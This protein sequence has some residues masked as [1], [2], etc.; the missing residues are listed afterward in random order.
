VH[1]AGQLANLNTDGPVGTRS[2]SGL[3]VDA[4]CPPFPATAKCAGVART[5]TM[6]SI[7][8]VSVVFEGNP[9]MRWRS[10]RSWM[11]QLGIRLLERTLVIFDC[12]ES[13]VIL[14]PRQVPQVGG[15]GR[16]GRPIRRQHTASRRHGNRIPLGWMT[17]THRLAA[18]AKVPATGGPAVSKF[19]WRVST[20]A[21]DFPKEPIRRVISGFVTVARS[22]GPRRDLRAEESR[23]HGGR[24]DTAQG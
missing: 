8:E 13:E 12:R 21:S 18:I 19:V 16:C 1:S 9:R 2:H 6:L 14:P 23:G 10:E 3:T 20:R 15:G 7:D 17:E 4:E 11:Y 22:S 5:M 24:A